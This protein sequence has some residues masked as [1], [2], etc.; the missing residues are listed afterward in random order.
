MLSPEEDYDTWALIITTVEDDLQ[1]FINF[2]PDIKRMLTSISQTGMLP[3]PISQRTDEFITM[4]SNIVSS[5]LNLYN[6]NETDYYAIIE[7]FQTIIEFCISQFKTRIQIALSILESCFSENYNLNSYN[8]SYEIRDTLIQFFL[9]LDGHQQMIEIIKSETTSLDNIIRISEIILKIKESIKLFDENEFSNII[10]DTFTRIANSDIRIFSVTAIEP[11]TS[12]LPKS[13][14]WLSLFITFLKTDLFDKRLFALKKIDQ[15]L[16]DKKYSNQMVNFL[17]ENIDTILS[18]PPHQEFYPL[19]GHICAESLKNDLISFD[20]IREFWNNQDYVHQ[21]EQNGFFSMFVK[22]SSDLPPEFCNDFVNLILHPKNKNIEWVKALSMIC[23]N[24]LTLSYE[25]EFNELRDELFQIGY[26]DITNLSLAARRGMVNLTAHNI[27]QLLPQIIDE[28][29]VKAPIDDILYVISLTLNSNEKVENTESVINYCF[30]H[31]NVNPSSTII[32]KLCIDHQAKITDIQLT[33]L[34]MNPTCVSSLYSAHIINDEMMDSYFT[35]LTSFDS[36]ISTIL[37]NYIFAHCGSVL[38]SLPIQKQDLLWDLTIKF[39]SYELCNG[40]ADIY[41]RNDGILLTDSMIITEF[42]KLFEHYY[43]KLNND[44]KKRPFLY[45]ILQEFIEKFEVNA[46]FESFK[47]QRH[48]PYQSDLIVYVNVPQLS[49]QITAASGNTVAVIVNKILNLIGKDQYSVLVTFNGQFLAYNYPINM[50][51]NTINANYRPYQIQE[52]NVKVQ[53]VRSE[54]PSLRICKCDLMKYLVDDLKEYGCWQLRILL[55]KLPTSVYLLQK[56]KNLQ[57]MNS[58]NFESLIMTDYPYYSIYVLES[59][60]GASLSFNDLQRTGCIS[61]IITIIPRFKIKAQLYLVLTFLTHLSDDQLNM[62]SDQLFDSLLRIVLSQDYAISAYCLPIMKRLKP[63][64]PPYEEYKLIPI[65]NFSPNTLP[66]P[67]LTTEDAKNDELKEIN[68]IE[69]TSQILSNVIVNFIFGSDGKT[70]VL[71][72]SNFSGFDIP[73]SYFTPHLDKVHEINCNSLL[74]VMSNALNE[75]N[76]ELADFAMNNFKIES[77]IFPFVIKVFLEQL[78]SGQ[79]DKEDHDKLAQIFDYIASNFLKADRPNDSPIISNTIFEILS[80]APSN[81]LLN[82]LEAIS[83]T[84]LADYDING[85]E[86]SVQ[87][88]TTGLKNL[89]MSCFLNATLQQFF[90]IPCVR[91][92]IIT[93]KND[94][95]PKNDDENKNLLFINEL[96]KLF[97]R[98]RDTV[99]SEVSPANVI[100]KWITWEGTKLNPHIQ[101]DA[102]EFVQ[103]L[104]DKLDL[105]KVIP[106]TTFNGSFVQV[107]ESIEDENIFKTTRNEGFSILPINIAPTLEEGFDK[108]HD[109]DYLTDYYAE[110][111]GKKIDAKKTEYLGKE[112]PDHLI[113]QLKRFKFEYT[114]YEKEKINDPVFFTEKI[115]IKNHC[116]EPMEDEKLYT[117]H[118]AGVIIHI[119]S[120]EGGH[121]ISY[122]K[123]RDTGNWYEYND[124]IVTPISLDFVMNNSNVNNQT[125][126]IL[127]YDK[128]DLSEIDDSQ[129]DPELQKEVTERNEQSKFY[130]VF[131][132]S[133]FEFFIN[134]LGKRKEM[135]KEVILYS[136]NV[137][138]HLKFNHDSVRDIIFQ[139]KDLILNDESNGRFYLENLKSFKP[140]LFDTPSYITKN[141]TCQNIYH[142]LLKKLKID[143]N[144]FKKLIDLFEQASVRINEAE[145]Y[146]M[147][148]YWASKYNL[149]LA[150]KFEVLKK[151]EGLI[152][153]IVETNTEQ[154]NEKEEANEN[155]QKLIQKQINIYSQLNFDWLT[156]IIIKLVPSK[157]FIEKIETNSEFFKLFILSSSDSRNYMKLYEYD[158]EKCEK[159]VLEFMTKNS[160]YIQMPICCGCL[161]TYMKEKSISIF[162]TLKFKMNNT[163]SNAADIAFCYVMLCRNM[164]CDNLLLDHFEEWFIP[165]SLN[166]NYDARILINQAV[167]QLIRHNKIKN[168]IGFMISRDKSNYPESYFDIETVDTVNSIEMMNRIKIILNCL[169]K[170]IEKVE[171]IIAKAI[172]QPFV[173]GTPEEVESSCWKIEQYQCSSY[174]QILSV[175]VDLFKSKFV[176]D[177]SDETKELS[178][179]LDLNRLKEFSH[180]LLKHSHP[181]DVHIRYIIKALKDDI[182]DDFIDGIAVTLFTEEKENENNEEEKPNISPLLVISSRIRNV[183]EELIPILQRRKSLKA[184]TIE[185][186]ARTLCFSNMKQMLNFQELVPPL[187]ITLSTFNKDAILQIIDSDMKKICQNNIVS[188]LFA[189]STM[190]EKRDISP[191]SE[192]CLSFNFI[193]F[194]DYIRLFVE[195]NNGI[196]PDIKHLFWNLNTGYYSLQTRKAIWE[197]ITYCDTKYTLFKQNFMNKDYGKSNGDYIEIANYLISRFDKEEQNE[198]NCIVIDLFKMSKMFI[199]VFSLS[200]QILKNNAVDAIKNKQFIGS[201]FSHIIGHNNEALHDYCLNV[202]FPML[203]TDEINLFFTDLFDFVL[204]NLQSYNIILLDPIRGAF[205][206]AV[207]NDK[208]DFTNVIVSLSFIIEVHLHPNDEIKQIINEILEKFAINDIWERINNEKV[209]RFRE[210]LIT[211]STM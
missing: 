41:S 202:A 184:S 59:L 190:E 69:S 31:I 130:S 47:L 120:A 189:L 70:R 42:L 92:A 116:Y 204:Q 169:L 48:K 26:V 191:Y 77:P 155:Q 29:K 57:K 135:A 160:L 167:L 49:R 165:L 132:S 51:G 71:F 181:Y 198:K 174:L 171:D 87:P 2:Y 82:R 63:K 138:P 137:L 72:S 147:V 55:N 93:Y 109:P 73:L 67:Q 156:K 1:S 10:C 117:Y 178:I 96:K 94:E 65:T 173:P 36:G 199:E 179:D 97:G 99:E 149:E 164:I 95:T 52:D 23:T 100:D 158:R 182:D 172:P 11:L 4:Q 125:A 66:V 102:S 187:I 86:C 168:E 16:N 54:I 162:P 18:L 90:A 91:K 28:E 122:V 110:S 121:Y 185:K 84:E 81:L 142:P 21:S 203:T 175:L 114:T 196:D 192:C 58:F 62:F 140:I 194:D 139:T 118:L 131:C 98:M 112:L 35:S 6:I 150:E 74:V 176:P 161:F 43:N 85:D 78:K 157:E 123:Q 88:T 60:F 127:F 37:L 103:M 163:I 177:S 34:M 186:I 107:I 205:D 5:F 208:N 193:T 195:C 180:F 144:T 53:L 68:T 136:I 115:D 12:K 111:L 40:I 20:K 170:N 153:S 201:L 33:Q 7:Y 159:L 148:L 14:K 50:L 61:Y 8:P 3:D 146:F 25:K 209:E 75:P 128:E 27:N 188:V 141:M 45:K 154:K 19:L 22:I 79:Y 104:I 133:P 106:K 105:G 200:Y 210:N 64:I 134:E 9:S 108:I 113:I 39:E 15:M 207:K 211:I 17:R 56:I 44:H 13:E 151:V 126:Y 89:G 24:F 206:D 129:L 46:D 30:K 124:T 145:Q 38:T 32:T 101:Q 152:V 76:K 80:K 83:H 119:G 166:D 183:L 143:E 197:Y